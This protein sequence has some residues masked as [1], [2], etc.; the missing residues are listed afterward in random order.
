MKK[1]LIILL[2]SIAVMTLVACTN[3]EETPIEDAPAEEYL[4]P[5]EEP[6]TTQTP[7]PIQAYDTIEEAQKALDFEVEMFDSAE[8][9]EGFTQENISIIAGELFQ[10]QY[11]NKDTKESLH[12]RVGKGKDDISGVYTEYPYMTS[13]SVDEITVELRGSTAES[14]SLIQFYDVDDDVMS[15]LSFDKE[16]RSTQDSILLVQHLI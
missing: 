2:A 13:E 6:S 15:S 3:N 14:I 16:G 4:E 5:I 12:Y 1:L 10:V 8:I 7:N 9:P 11:I